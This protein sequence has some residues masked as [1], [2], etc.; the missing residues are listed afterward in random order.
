MPRQSSERTFVI[1]SIEFARQWQRL[2]GTIALRDFERLADQLVGVEGSVSFFVAGEAQEGGDKFLSLSIEANLPL[3]CQRCLGTIDLPLHLKSRL[4]LVESGKEWPDE[5]LDD[6]SADAIAADR[7]LNL[8]PLIEDELM[9]ALP[10]APRHDECKAP[11]FAGKNGRA[12]P[13]AGLAE[14]KKIRV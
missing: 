1:D 9:L 13:F 2:S 10:L 6:D 4:L 14:L 3:R 12:L 7:A 5:G 11:D 8:A